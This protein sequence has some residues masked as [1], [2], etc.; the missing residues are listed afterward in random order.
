MM[1]R[2]SPLPGE[3]NDE[4]TVFLDSWRRMLALLDVELL[5]PVAVEVQ[6]SRLDLWAGRCGNGA[7]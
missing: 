6:D 4:R 2:L 7:E 5:P 1:V 3:S